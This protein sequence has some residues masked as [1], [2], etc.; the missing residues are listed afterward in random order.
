MAK[1]VKN[2]KKTLKKLSSKG[3]K[4]VIPNPK[5]FIV[6]GSNTQKSAKPIQGSKKS[7]SQR[8]KDVSEG[9]GIAARHIKVEAGKHV[10]M[11]HEN[12]TP[13]RQK[14]V[15]KEFDKNAHEILKLQQSVENIHGE[16]LKL[17]KDN[18]QLKQ[19]LYNSASSFNSEARIQNIPVDIYLDTDDSLMIFSIYETVMEFLA[20]IDFVK[21][22]EFD[23]VN[24]SWFKSLVAKS[25]KVMT[26]EEVLSRLRE[27]EYSV[28]VNAILKQQSEIDK[29]LAE[30]LLNITKS[31]ENVPNAAIRIGSLIVVKLTNKEGEVNIQ[32]RTLTIQELYILN[33]RPELLHKPHEV[34]N[35]LTACINEG[36]NDRLTS[37]N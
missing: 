12:V 1:K 9:E 20:T 16:L 13:L 35:A 25:V 22:F 26:S 10:V 23:A 33:K 34:L 24:G 3:D 21:V 30:A 28:Q 5:N 8:N 29:N 2:I 19:Y 18:L 6:I 27:V 17:Q 32:S 11:V 31:I 14:L 15:L 37:N 36:K 4:H 7:I